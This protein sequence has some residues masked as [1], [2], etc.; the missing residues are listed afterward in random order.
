MLWGRN[1]RWRSRVDLHLLLAGLLFLVRPTDTIAGELQVRLI[2]P[3][4]IE[5][6]PGKIITAS[7]LVSNDT[8][9]DEQFTEALALPLGWQQVAPTD[10]F[11]IVKANSQQVRVAALLVPAASPAGR[12]T[13]GYSMRGQ[14][15]QALADNAEFTVAVQTV[16]K[17]EL[18]IDEQPPVVLAGESYDV[19][20]RV[21]NRG[22]KQAV[23]R[24][25]AEAV[26]DR[27]VNYDRTLLEL[28]PGTSQSV[29]LSASTDGT[30][31]KRM[32]QVLSIKAVTESGAIVA[33]KNAV[34]E[35]LPQV[36]GDSDPYNRLPTRLSFITVKDSGKSEAFQAQ[37][38]GGGNL[39]ENGERQLYF[40]AR[41][42]NTERDSVLGTPDEF[43]VNYV[44]K[45]FNAYLGDRNYSLSPL[46]ERSGYGR[47]G[48][49]DVHRGSTSF[50]AF[51]MDSL[52]QP[53]D[54]NEIGAHAQQQFTPWLSFK[55]NVL[56]RDGSDRMAITN[57]VSQDLYSLESRLSFGKAAE[58]NLEG[59]IG[60]EDRNHQGNNF[61]YR[62]QASG[63]LA[64]NIF[65]SIED[66]YS[67]PRFFGYYNDS[68]FAQGSVTFP[69]YEKLA[70]QL[71]LSK[72]RQQPRPGPG[73]W[74]HRHS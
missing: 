17:I 46:T 25:Q 11:F 59:G 21:I 48:E 68:D 30:I 53:S 14:R 10:P 57:G 56:H 69:I 34:V 37:Y 1:T 60:E 20:M 8:G 62:A 38:S 9:R 45:A 7:F 39:D 24:V 54:F 44:D 22:N 4:L 65:Y 55:A 73:A 23:L 49:L 6:A 33:A 41:S 74:P 66:A 3:N 18:L 70:R 50:G 16:S 32:L 43:W 26:P 47:G 35:I 12:S 64:K 19:S 72:L 61:A 63:E 2:S 36:T 67:G 5:T 52:L 42:P 28:A 71:Q 31:H 13:V 27:P 58:I 29:R 51:Y 40:L 15:N